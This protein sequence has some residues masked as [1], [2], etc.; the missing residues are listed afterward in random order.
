MTSDATTFRDEPWGRWAALT[1][2]MNDDV[3]GNITHNY[4]NFY[5]KCAF[6]K[7]YLDRA[8][9]DFLGHGNAR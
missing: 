6:A 5:H 8:A 4:D 1:Q 7:L 2:Q 3:P 9:R